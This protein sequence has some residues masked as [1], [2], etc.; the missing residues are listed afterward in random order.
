MTTK[1][2]NEAGL[3]GNE[4]AESRF[5]KHVIEGVLI[6]FALVVVIAAILIRAEG[7]GFFQSSGNQKAPVS[8]W[9]PGM[10]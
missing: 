6:F 10:P 2:L 9:P 5:Q 3:G 8:A 7:N 4:D 1:V